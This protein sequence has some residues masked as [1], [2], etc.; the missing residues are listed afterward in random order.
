MSKRMS[1]ILILFMAIQHL[2]YELAYKYRLIIIVNWLLLIF[3]K[4]GL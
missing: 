1:L 3:I 4:I 2:H